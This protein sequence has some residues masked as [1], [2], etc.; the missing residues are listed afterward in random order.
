MR[1][2]AKHA[3]ESFS[4]T[5]RHGLADGVCVHWLVVGK[6]RTRWASEHRVL[7]AEPLSKAADVLT[8]VA[9]GQACSRNRTMERGGALA[10][11]IQRQVAILASA[12]R[13]RP[14]HASSQSAC[15]S[16]RSSSKGSRLLWQNPFPAVT[17]CAIVRVVQCERPS[18]YGAHGAL[19]HTLARTVRV[20]ATISKVSG[21]QQT[22]SQNKAAG[23]FIV[24]ITDYHLHHHHHHHRH[25]HHHHQRPQHT[26]ESAMRSSLWWTQHTPQPAEERLAVTFEFFAQAPVSGRSAADHVVWAPTGTEEPVAPPIV[27]AVWWLIEERTLRT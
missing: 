13:R 20:Q 14:Q 27:A 24:I 7:S 2:W 5:C 8:C 16:V 11:T 19:V 18:R 21:A 3:V 22:C 23:I 10:E 12:R 6:I 26:G 25:L 15:G 9:L 4:C 17:R 1:E